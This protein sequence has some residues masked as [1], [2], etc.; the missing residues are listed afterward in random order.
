[1]VVE[2]PEIEGPQEFDPVCGME[3]LADHPHRVAAIE[4]DGK[5]F[6]F[7]SDACRHRFKADPD[8]FVIGRAGPIEELSVV[9][10]SGQTPTAEKG[11]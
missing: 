10:S 9:G 4:I 2:A 8:R 6:H 11:G 3:F 5:I 7:C 1:M